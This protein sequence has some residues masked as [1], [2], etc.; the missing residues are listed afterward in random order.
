MRE[1]RAAATLARSPAF[2]LVATAATILLAVGCVSG[3][4]SAK[5]TPAPPT[6]A[7]SAGCA[8]D[9]AVAAGISD[10]TLMSGGVARKYEL[11][12][13]ASYDGTKPF[14]LVF[15]LHPLSISYTVMPSQVGFDR[16]SP[17]RSSWTHLWYSHHVPIS[18]KRFCRSD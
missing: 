2:L 4:G 9:A 11:D 1:L 14:A 15:G 13:P 5:D 3:G 10:H 17:C 6:P 8:T 16:R 12:V 7:A 18:G